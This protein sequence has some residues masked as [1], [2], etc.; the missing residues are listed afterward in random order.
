MCLIKYKNELKGTYKLGRVISVKKGADGLVRTVRLAY[1]NAN[2]KCMREVD[3]PIHGIAVIVPVEEQ[4]PSN[5]NPKADS[6]EPSK[7]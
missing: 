1:K 7:T 6:F 3:R 5:L 4:V 2:E